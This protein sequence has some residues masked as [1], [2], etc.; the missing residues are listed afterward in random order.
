[1]VRLEN[2]NLTLKQ[3]QKQFENDFKAQQA[4]RDKLA[5]DYEAWK[6]DPVQAFIANKGDPRRLADTILQGNQPREVP[7]EFAELKGEL[8]AL[9][10]WKESQETARARETEEMGFRHYASQVGE[11][12]D[13]DQNFA[14]LKDAL[15]IMGALGANVDLAQAVRAPIERHFQET[16]RLLSAQEVA[17]T[18]LPEAQRIVENMKA[19]A[20]IKRLFASQPAPQMQEQS[21]PPIAPAGSLSSS[22]QQ[23]SPTVDKSKLGHNERLKLMEQALRKA[24]RQP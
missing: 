7:P 11:L 4:E 18:L 6:K 20:V 5:K 14:A 9:R 15:D 1:M 8:Q 19:N 3:R 13:K 22:M 17:A 12:M 2:E 21:Q 16:G 24:T 23:D 10:E